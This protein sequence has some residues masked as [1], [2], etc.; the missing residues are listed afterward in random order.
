MIDTLIE[1]NPHLKAIPLAEH[2]FRTLLPTH[3][4]VRGDLIF[5]DQNFVRL[6]PHFSNHSARFLHGARVRFLFILTLLLARKNGENKT[7]N[8]T[9]ILSFVFIGLAIGE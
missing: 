9:F 1:T 5:K 8:S 7:K 4:V 6:L 2:W 3:T